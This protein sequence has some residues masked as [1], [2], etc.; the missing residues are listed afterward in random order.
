VNAVILA[1]LGRWIV[2]AEPDPAKGKIILRVWCW[3]DSGGYTFK[4][5]EYPLPWE[6][7][8]RSAALAAVY[9]AIRLHAQDTRTRDILEEAREIVTSRL[10]P[11]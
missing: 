7:S 5:H 9:K 10:G 6:R 1:Q 2:T 11:A 4:G 3:E 8:V